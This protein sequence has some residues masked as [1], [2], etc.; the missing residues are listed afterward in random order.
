MVAFQQT[1]IEHLDVSRPCCIQWRQTSW[2]QGEKK[3]PVIMILTSGI[4]ITDFKTL[5]PLSP[6]VLSK[7]L[8]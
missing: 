5:L 2:V 6:P 7:Y 4:F 1:F 3:A 8:C